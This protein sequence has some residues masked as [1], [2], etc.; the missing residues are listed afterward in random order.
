MQTPQNVQTKRPRLVSNHFVRRSKVSGGV[1]VKLY[2]RAIENASSPPLVNKW[3]RR[4]RFVRSPRGLG[5]AGCSVIMTFC[6][7]VLFALLTS[8]GTSGRPSFSSTFPSPFPG[9]GDNDTPIPFHARCPSHPDDPWTHGVNR[10]DWNSCGT[11][12]SPGRYDHIRE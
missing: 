5:R 8:H 12:P 2:P 6:S 1:C 3:P 7:F 10:S 4:C 11:T 9:Q